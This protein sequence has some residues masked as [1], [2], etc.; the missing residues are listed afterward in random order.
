VLLIME[1]KFNFKRL[2]CVIIGLG[3]AVAAGFGIVIA[4]AIAIGAMIALVTE[5]NRSENKP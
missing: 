2:L 5:N 4:R 1:N 3:A